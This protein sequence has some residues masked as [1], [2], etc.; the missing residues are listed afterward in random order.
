MQSAHQI[1]QQYALEILSQ[2]PIDYKNKQK[3]YSNLLSR[4]IKEFFGFFNYFSYKKKKERK[5]EKGFAHK[6]GVPLFKQHVLG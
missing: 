4:G 2:F 3:Q 1:V 6:L 5:K